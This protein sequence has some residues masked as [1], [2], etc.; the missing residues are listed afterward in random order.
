[1][2]GCTGLHV[3]GCVVIADACSRMRWDGPNLKRRRLSHGV[4]A[5]ALA[6]AMGVSRVRVHVIERGHIES[7]TA[8]AYLAALTRA[9]LERL[10]RWSAPSSSGFG[11]Q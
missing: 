5:R 2:Q 1:M 11:A 9:K 8:R 3:L 10:R 7:E 4:T 6:D